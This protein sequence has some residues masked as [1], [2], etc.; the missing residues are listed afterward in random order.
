MAENVLYKNECYAIVGT[1]MEVYNELGYG[2]LEAVYQ[3]A[4][5]IELTK[6]GIHFEREKRLQISYK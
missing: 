2:F 5:A 1:A 4:F 3:E 6:R